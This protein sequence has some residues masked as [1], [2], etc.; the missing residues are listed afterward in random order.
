MPQICKTIQEKIEETRQEARQ[1]CK[2]VSRTITETI[3]SWMPWPLDDLCNAISRVIT[4]VICTTIWVLITVISW[5]TKVVCEVISIIDWIISHTI[6]FLEWL[7][8][9]ILT[10][11]EWLGCLI[12][13]KGYNK[14]FRICPMVLTTNEGKPIVPIATIQR[15]ID[16][17]IKIY[18]EECNINVLASPI[19]IKPET[20]HLL[21]VSA[22][23]A[24]AYFHG[25]RMELNQLACCN[26]GFLDSIKCLRFPSG[27][28]WPMK[29]LRA[30]W[31]DTIDGGKRGCFMP[32]ES[33]ILIASSGAVDTL[34]HEMGHAG[35]L[36]HTDDTGNLMNTPSRT[37]SNLSS[38]QC[39]TV[40]TSKF[41]S[42]F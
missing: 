33:Y 5:I 32:M 30:I 26:G 27:L 28:V 35:D 42:I 10:F 34:A 7:V 36:A 6:G 29:T 24:G 3:C 22:C 11:P 13:I 31:V 18:K 38:L 40:R 2:N 14:N 20:S 15:Q 17:A 37:D 9:R 12:G 16:T 23:D 4:E 39:C 19:V 1:E 21:Q 41:V 8:N 25:D